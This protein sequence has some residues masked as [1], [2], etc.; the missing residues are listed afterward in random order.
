MV[1]EDGFGAGGRRG[2]ER[3]EKEG[4][5]KKR[6]KIC[7]GERRDETRESVMGWTEQT[8]QDKTED[9]TGTGQDREPT[10]QCQPNSG[11]VLPPN[12]FKRQKGEFCP[13]IRLHHPSL[14][15]FPALFHNFWNDK[16]KKKEKKREERNKGKEETCIIFIRDDSQ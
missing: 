7:G 13:T 9:G 1:I 2:E 16:T 4:N 6:R 5:K 8:R 3:R 12:E 15:F 10:G 14:A 11:R